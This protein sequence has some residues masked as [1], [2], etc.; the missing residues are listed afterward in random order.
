ML[1]R[2]RRLA[3]QPANPI[4]FVILGSSEWYCPYPVDV[5]FCLRCCFLVSHEAAA[6]G[7]EWSDTELVAFS[8]AI[9]AGRVL[10]TA[11]ATDPDTGGI[12]TYVT[13]EV[14][15]V[16]KGGIATS[17]VT[18]K[19]LGGEVG[20]VGFGVAE[21]AVFVPNE[22]VVVFLEQRPRDGME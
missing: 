16:I 15:D 8:R 22:Q 4:A 6:Q 7:P 9:V 5:S 21:Q 13:I 12:Y 17:T 20:E 19:Q 10:A 2:T 14:S 1:S 18:L 11:S 3:S